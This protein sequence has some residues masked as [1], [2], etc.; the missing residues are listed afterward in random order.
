MLA[1]SANWFTPWLIVRR[2]IF[3]ATDD[4]DSPGDKG[5]SG[6]KP[7]KKPRRIGEDLLDSNYMFNRRE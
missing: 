7:L 3:E 4:R 2:D 6:I 1:G 5:S